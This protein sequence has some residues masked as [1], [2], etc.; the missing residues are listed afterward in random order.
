MQ[1][2]WHLGHLNRTGIADNQRRGAISFLNCHWVAHQYSRCCHR[3]PARSH[4][5]MLEHGLRFSERQAL[6]MPP[7]PVSHG[8]RGSGRSRRRPSDRQLATGAPTS[9][10]I[11]EAVWIA[12][13]LRVG[14]CCQRRHRNFRLSGTFPRGR[15]RRSKDASMDKSAASKNAATPPH[16][17]GRAPVG[18]E[19]LVWRNW[20]RPS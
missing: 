12:P 5:E 13:V 17:E 18:D 15:G 8:N 1:W 20:P 9:Y 4:T 3:H 6:G 10:S 7:L 11:R 19:R 2:T 14:V 16:P